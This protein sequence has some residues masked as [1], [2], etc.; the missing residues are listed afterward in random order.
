M[1]G[2][3]LGL[4]VAIVAVASAVAHRGG[5]S[6]AEVKAAVAESHKQD[7]DKALARRTFVRGLGNDRISTEGRRDEG[8]YI[9]MSVDDD[10]NI[11]TLGL[12]LQKVSTQLSVLQFEWAR[13]SNG[14]RITAPWTEARE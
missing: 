14:F 11:N 9:T 5:M 8:L 6:D 13:C 1:I 4:G 3:L 7:A 10:C 12:L 2:A